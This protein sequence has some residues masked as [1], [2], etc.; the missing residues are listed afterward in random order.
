MSVEFIS[1]RRLDRFWNAARI[2]GADVIV[3]VTGDNPLLD[4]AIMDAAVS[5][6][7]GLG[8]EYAGTADC[9]LG[10]G[11][12]VFT[13]TSLDRAFR[14]AAAAGVVLGDPFVCEL[15]GLDFREDVS[16]IG[17]DVV[18]DDASLALIPRVSLGRRPVGRGT[19]GASDAV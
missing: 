18:I 19:G 8:I 6:F 4:P 13:F 17:T 7:L 12:E 2:A 16:E 14:E 10:S 1:G 9:P 15:P 11:A 3:R 5:V